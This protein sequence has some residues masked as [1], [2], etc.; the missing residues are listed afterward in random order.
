MGARELLHELDAFEGLPAVDANAMRGAL[1]LVEYSVSTWRTI[2]DE[3]AADQAAA[4]ALRLFEWLT[5]RP[6]WRR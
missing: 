2:V 4:H 3:G 5:A 6:D 1:R